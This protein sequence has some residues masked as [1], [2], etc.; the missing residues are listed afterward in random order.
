MHSHLVAVEVRVER[1]ADERMQLNGTALNEDRLKRLNAQA[2]QRRC[3]VQHDRV[4]LDDNLQCVP[5][6]ALRALYSLS[7]SL[8]VAGGTGLDKALHNKR[9]KEL[10]C[11]FLRQAALVHFQL[12]ADNDNGTAGIVNTLTEQVLTEAAL[13]ALQHIGKGL[14]RAVVRAGDR[15][16]AA[17][18]VDEGIDG[19]LQHTLLVAHDD[20]RRAELDESLQTVV[21]VDNASVQVVQV[22][23]CKAAAVQLY[24]RTDI[25]RDNRHGIEDHPLR[26]VTGDA[27]GFHNLKTLENVHALLSLRGFEVFFELLAE[28]FAVDILEQ[29]LHSFSAHGRLEVVLIFFTH[30]AVFLFGERL[31]LRELTDGTRIRNDVK[32]EIQNLFQYARGKVKNQTHAGRDALK[33]PDVRN[34]RC[35][36][37][38]T[39]ALTAN[40]AA[41]H[42][43]AAALADLALK[44]D[45]LILAAMALPVL[46][47]SENALAVKAVALRLQCTVV[48]GLGLR[49]LTV[50]PGAN[51]LGRCKADL[52]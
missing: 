4:V 41:R 19:F 26:A 11:H 5:N 50:R 16:A 37:N 12:R 44:A 8:D 39:H 31:H 51:L 28:L 1:G 52:Y 17:A 49:D 34:R 9:L 6:L 38:V 30:V 27:E 15:S 21:S 20:V 29:L 14:E 45:A 2:V 3:T 46:C 10:Q 23:R 42:F 36:L 43:N 32:C 25:R 24:E 35:K 40:L 48:D 33:V 13:L 22:T 18:V 47:R 7:C